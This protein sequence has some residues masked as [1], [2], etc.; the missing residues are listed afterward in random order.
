MM[1]RPS[2]PFGVTILAVLEMLIG[3]VGLLASIALIGLSALFASL[4]TIRGLV[5]SVGLV[6]GGI[7]F[8]L[9]S[10]LACHW[11]RVLA[12]KG[13]GLDPRNGLQRSLV[14]R[15]CWCFSCWSDYWW[16]R[17]VFLLVPDA[18]LSYKKSCESFLRKRSAST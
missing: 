3:I 7:A 14:A 8:F 16:N 2:R 4:P 5:A 11:S 9:Q 17:R 18:L 12:W 1:Q 13:L 15:C 10:H 6:I